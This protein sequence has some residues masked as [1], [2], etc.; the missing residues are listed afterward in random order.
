MYLVVVVF[1]KR[2]DLLV[3]TTIEIK[4]VPIEKKELVSWHSDTF[5]VCCLPCGGRGGNHV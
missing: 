4:I 2:F 1:T 3:G 5:F